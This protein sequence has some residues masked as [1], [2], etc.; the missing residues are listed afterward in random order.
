MAKHITLETIK[1]FEQELTC[2]PNVTQALQELADTYGAENMALATTSPEDR[3]HV[4]LIHAVDPVTR[5]NARLHEFFPEGQ[6]RR[7]GYGHTNKYH[8]AFGALGWEPAQTVVVEDSLSGVTKAKAHSQQVRVVGTVAAKFF[9]NKTA[10]AATLLKAGA[11]MVI[12]DMVD[13]P[14][15]VAWLSKGM[16]PNQRPAFQSDVYVPQLGMPVPRMRVY[17]P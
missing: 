6:R 12:S 5:E 4:S 9:E 3:M 2:T 15:A 13:L 8:E 14:K 10:Q 16:D 11:N 1:R 7:S 17:H